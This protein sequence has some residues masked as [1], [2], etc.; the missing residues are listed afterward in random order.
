M[1]ELKYKTIFIFRQMEDNPIII[2]HRYKLK[3]QDL[4]IQF[5]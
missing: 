4:K 3:P 1:L 5:M 2:F